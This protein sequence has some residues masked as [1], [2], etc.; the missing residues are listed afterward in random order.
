MSEV[1]VEMS[2]EEVERL[3]G[4]ARRFGIYPSLILEP[5]APDYDWWK[6]N[7]D[8]HCDPAIRAAAWAQAKEACDRQKRQHE[9]WLA[10]PAAER[11]LLLTALRLRAEQLEREES[12]RKKTRE[13]ADKREERID[14]LRRAGASWRAEDQEMLESGEFPACSATQAYERFLS[15]AKPWL[16][17]TGPTGVG[18]S[19]VG[20]RAIADATHAAFWI[21]GYELSQAYASSDF[22]IR[23]DVLDLQETLR[24]VP[25]LAIDELSS[26]EIG[27]HPARMALALVD[28]LNARANRSET[29]TIVTS[30]VRV[31]EML[32][33]LKDPR[34]ESRFD[35]LVEWIPVGGNDMRKQATLKQ[36]PIP[37]QPHGGTRAFRPMNQA[38]IDS[39]RH[40]SRRPLK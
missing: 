14:R 27:A 25:L 39:A 19:L 8:R 32:A 24:S 20:L 28:L 15:S 21:S 4:E 10:T 37:L 17:L 31:P 23:Q 30:N 40:P 3:V 6:R 16:V 12:A 34:I 33:L 13:L 2:P 7:T 36:A 11:E 38:D 22:Q 5:V 29:W 35:G 1:S 18:K 26:Y 9:E